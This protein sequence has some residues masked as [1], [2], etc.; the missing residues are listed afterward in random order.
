MN[1]REPGPLV[2][3]EW[4]AAH[5]GE[6]DLRV[7]HVSLDRNVYEQGHV[8]GA[9]FS[10]LHVDLA[11]A[12][13]A[14]AT[15]AA[16]RTYLIPTRQETQAS[17]AAWGVAPG[18]RVVF[19]DDAGQNRHAIRG[20]W[21]LRLYRF[22]A[23]RVHV[24][25]GG[26]PAWQADGQAVT[27]DEPAAALV[28]VAEPL[29]VRDRA[30][31]ATADDVLAWSREASVPGGPTRI[32]DVRSIDEFLG[33]D[34]RAARGGRVPGAQHRLFSDFVAPDGRLR[35]A[36]DLRAILKG[37]GVNP[38][39]L[40]ATY[41]QGGVRAALAWFVLSEVAGLHEVR[42]YAE[43]WEEWGNRPDLPVER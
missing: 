1:A 36:A 5:L 6:P 8:P 11:K 21:L 16:K 32:L 9:V 20:Y 29:G 7:I 33:R 14:A 38:D 34:V 35:P 41:C 2:S 26:L 39:E 19:Y 12:G 18:S 40:R 23:D 15:G 10:D 27:T 37:T 42:N 4:L 31:L 24:L 28:A 25:D 22:P 17:L 13:M 30:L 3:G 43:S